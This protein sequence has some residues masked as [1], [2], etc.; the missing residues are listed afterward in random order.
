MALV[1][2]GVEVNV[3]DE[4]FY[5]PAAAGT[6]PMIFVASAENKP[7]SSGT[8]IARGTAKSNAGVPFLLTSQR[9]LAETFG[10][11]VFQTDNNNNPINA[12]EL[13]EYGLQAAY[14]VLGVTNRAW[15]TRA[16]VDLGALEPTAIEPAAD[17]ANGT[18]W[19][20]TDASEYGVFEWS[21]ATTGA[22]F[23]SR[24]P[25]LVTSSADYAFGT[26]SVNGTDG[27]IPKGSVG[28]VGDYAIVFASTVIRLFYKNTDG[29]WVLVGSDAWTKS[30]PTVKSTKSPSP[31]EGGTFN[32]ND[33]EIS[34]G[35]GNSAEDIAADINGKN[36]SGV[37]AAAQD[38]RLVIFSDGTDSG[39]DS[40]QSG[41][42][43]LDTFV[44]NNDGEGDPTDLAAEIGLEDFLNDQGIGTFYPPFLQISKHTQVPRFKSDDDYPRPLGSIWIKTT[45]PGGGARWRM[46]VYEEGSELWQEIDAPLYETNQ[47]ALFELDRTDGGINLAVGDTY[48]NYNVAN[49]TNQLATFKVYRRAGVFPTTVRSGTVQLTD[50]ASYEIKISATQPA[51]QSFTAAQTVAFTAGDNAG[52]TAENFASS[53]NAIGITGLSASVSGTGTIVLEH[54][55]GGDILLTD[56]T[57]NAVLNALGFSAY[58]GPNAGTRNLYYAGGTDDQTNPLQLQASLWKATEFDSNVGLNGEEVAFYTASPN[59][60]TAL[61]RNDTLWYNSVVDEVDL[62]IHNGETWV[63]YKNFNSAYEDTDPN[64]PI[65]SAS[66]PVLQT[67]G[68]ELVTGDIWV[69][70][71]EIESYPRIYRFD[72]DIPNTPIRNRWVELDTSDQTSEDGVLFADARWGDSG[73]GSDTAASIIDLQLSN[74]LDP[75]APDPALYPRGMLLWNLRRSGFNVKRFVRDYIDQNQ[76]NPRQDDES[77][78][79]YYPH[80]WVTESAN[81]EDGS[82]SFGRKAQRRVIL[83]AMQATLNSND[84][85]RDAES[86]QFNLMAAP[87]YPELIGEMVTLNFDRGL[88]AFVI[89]DAPARLESD[90][91]TLNNWATNQNNAFEDSLEGLVS[92]DEYLGIFYPYGFTSDNFGNN[93]VVPPSHMILRTMILSDQVSFPWF[94]PAGIRRG[95]ITNATSVGYVNDEGEFRSVAL[96]E[97][98]RDIL[99]ENNVN[100]ITFLSGAGLVNYGQKTRARGASALDRINVAR[101][102]V[103]LRGQ[104]NQLAKPYIFEQNDKITRDE[105][106]QATESLL[107]ELVGQRALNDFLVVCDESNNTP[108]RIDRNELYLDIAI[109]PVKA[110]EFIYIPLRLKN[111][112]E[113]ASL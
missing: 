59:E 70:T 53:V 73:E 43:V 12:G 84:D 42:V 20:D 109:E 56:D 82:G 30:W 108:S 112:G 48:V 77:M 75:D 40:T 71:S 64:G 85:I 103:F 57:D 32:L 81:Q 101:L 39:P 95:G 10:D 94:A 63:G 22:T 46:K 89:G 90:G 19:L 65:V 9:D 69:D 91:T 29:V 28:S 11:P 60:V 86:R 14:S 24:T 96:N 49:D 62:M 78:E 113:I 102:V 54:G 23:A 98:Q 72:A 88:T 7:N 51:Q 4:S 27:N 110:V 61:T 83:Q 33:T 13:N 105:I 100:P 45:E 99:Y 8:G 26:A 34:V 76:D 68:N 15:V 97:G 74:Y 16:D 111:T 55:T 18:Y 31:T 37:T 36:I 58:E 87:G 52:D 44:G 104:L 106:K 107:L 41:V 6:T 50:E 25:I 93:V 38:S 3:I 47:Q 67:E 1:S 35:A 66:K 2:P 5:V 80:R 21:G 17:P 92:R 79:N